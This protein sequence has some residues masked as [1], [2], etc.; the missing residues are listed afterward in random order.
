MPG[1]P[2]TKR[3]ASGGALAAFVDRAPGRLVVLGARLVLAALFAAAAVPK[4]LDPVS[5]ARDV[6]N[7]HLLSPELVALVAVALPPLELVLALALL[8]GVH[9]RGAAL[10]TGGLL[11]A[12][13]AGMAQ[14]IARGIDLDCGCFGSAMAMEVS[15]WTIARN[16]VLTLLAW[17]VAAA[18]DV[19]F[20]GPRRRSISAPPPASA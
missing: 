16:L 11:L 2:V 8:T 18:P 17:L 1:V 20:L 10:V 4:I 5:F 14:A 7:Y 19:P 9:A 3:S 6:E 12:F 15:G 13:A